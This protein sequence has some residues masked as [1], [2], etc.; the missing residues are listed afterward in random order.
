M[1]IT[2]ISDGHISI[3]LEAT[4]TQSSMLVVLYILRI[5]MSPWRDAKSRSL[6]LWS[7][8][9]CTFLRLPAP[10]FWRGDHNWWVITTVWDLVYSFLEPDLRISPPVGCHVTSK[11]TQCWYH[12]NS[13]HFIFALAEARSLW[14]WLQV[15]RSKPCVLAAMII[16][17]PAGLFC[18][19][20]ALPDT[21]R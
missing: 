5:L 3:L 15:G 21:N 11:F 20:G 13:L 4:V 18:R 6:T 9:N 10:L 2:R 19:T 8:E 1:D 17:P 14:L 12:Q 16:S 7:C